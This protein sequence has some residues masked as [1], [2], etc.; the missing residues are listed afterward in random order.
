M[1]NINNFG[2]NLFKL[3]KLKNLNQKDLVVALGLS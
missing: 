2:N 3:R 1:S